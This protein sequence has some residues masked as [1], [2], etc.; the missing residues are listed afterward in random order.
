MYATGVF[1]AR[2]RHLS[3]PKNF[4]S[5]GGDGAHWAPARENFLKFCIHE[6][7]LHAIL[8]SKSCK[9]SIDFEQILKISNDWL[10]FWTNFF[11]TMF[12]LYKKNV[13]KPKFSQKKFFFFESFMWYRLRSVATLIGSLIGNLLLPRENFEYFGYTMHI[14]MSY[15]S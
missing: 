7:Y 11:A 6:H 5:L 15:L 2:D 13:S 4:L 3:V 14:C 10:K 12:L 9:F 8:M 1:C